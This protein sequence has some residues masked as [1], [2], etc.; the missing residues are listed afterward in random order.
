MGQ[1]MNRKEI[2]QSGRMV[3][4]LTD[5][6]GVDVKVNNQVDFDNFMKGVKP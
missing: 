5:K 4:T 1:D 3:A 6:N 2:E